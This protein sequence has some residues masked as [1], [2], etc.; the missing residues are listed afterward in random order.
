MLRELRQDLALYRDVC[1]VSYGRHTHTQELTHS[2][3]FISLLYASCAKA[4]TWLSIAMY[5]IQFVDGAE[6][7]E[8]VERPA[9]V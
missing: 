5:D 8:Y 7:A 4:G 2:A 9:P 6:A 1:F 3:H